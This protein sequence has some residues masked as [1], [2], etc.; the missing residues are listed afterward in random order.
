M[1]FH[2]IDWPLNVKVIDCI[3]FLLTWLFS[4]LL[5]NLMSD[6]CHVTGSYK[7]HSRFLSSVSEFL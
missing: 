1:E 6:V 3:N 7:T 5:V 2:H 4:F